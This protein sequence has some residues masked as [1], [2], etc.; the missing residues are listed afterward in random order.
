MYVTGKYKTGIYIG[1]VVEE[2]GE[3]TLLQVKAVKKHPMQGDLHQGFATDV[4]L[5]HQRNALAYLEKAWVP[6]VTV[7]AYSDD[8]PSYEESLHEAV[9]AEISKMEKRED[10]F[11]EKA[12]SSLKEL[13]TR[14]EK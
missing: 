14:Y 11:G 4:P 1:E 2:R 10:E 3:R 12:L 6:T 9:E 7:K 8:L 5:F 13:Q